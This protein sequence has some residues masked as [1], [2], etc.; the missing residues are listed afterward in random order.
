MC[1]TDVV[2]S[3]VRM[4]GRSGLE[5]LSQFRQTNGSTPFVVITAFGSEEVHA[6]ARELGATFVF[7]KPFEMDGLRALPA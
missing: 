5:A 3:D 4:P 7:D 1:R 6:Q 2:I